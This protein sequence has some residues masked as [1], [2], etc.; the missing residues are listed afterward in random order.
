MIRGRFEGLY[1][2]KEVGMKRIRKVLSLLL[3]FILV[4]SIGMDV[5]AI[6]IK[7]SSL[8]VS[9]N[10]KRISDSSAVK[11]VDNL[12]FVGMRAVATGAKI[13]VSWDSKKN[14]MTVKNGKKI[15]K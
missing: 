3:A 13:A 1:D 6:S 10:G 11:K 5:N 4:F 8:D 7:E 2:L 12:V 15:I 14:T 9:I